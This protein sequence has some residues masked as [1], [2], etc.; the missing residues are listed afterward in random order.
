MVL[1]EGTTPCLCTVS[2]HRLTIVLTM[3]CLGSSRLCVRVQEKLCHLRQ[4]PQVRRKTYACARFKFGISPPRTLLRDTQ[5][6]L[7]TTL[8]LF[9]IIWLFSAVFVVNLK[10]TTNVLD[11]TKSTFFKLCRLKFL[12]KQFQLIFAPISDVFCKSLNRSVIWVAIY[13]KLFIRI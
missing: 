7:N 5:V 8:C 2:N 3:A 13:F 1:V 6:R 10:N 12:K 4:S 11:I 9:N